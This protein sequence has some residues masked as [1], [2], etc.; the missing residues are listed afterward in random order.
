VF[1]DFKTTFSAG[2]KS[3][4]KEEGKAVPTS[5]DWTL[6]KTGT[7]S[8]KDGTETRVDE[9]IH[10]K[11]GDKVAITYSRNEG[12]TDAFAYKSA[13][14]YVVVPSYSNNDV[15]GFFDQNHS[16]VTARVDDLKLYSGVGHPDYADD[17][18]DTEGV[19]NAVRFA[20]LATTLDQSG[21]GNV[22]AKYGG[23][24][25]VIFTTNF[26]SSKVTA[27]S[28]TVDG[29]TV[30]YVSLASGENDST[31]SLGANHT[32]GKVF[33]A[34]LTFR[35]ITN[36]TKVFHLIRLRRQGEN[37]TSA[38]SQDIIKYSKNSNTIYFDYNGKVAY[39]CD[40]AGKKLT[41]S[42]NEW[43]T[44]R[45]VIDERGNKPLVSVYIN[46]KIANFFTDDALVPRKAINLEGIISDDFSAHRNDVDQKV[47][48]F[49]TIASS[50]NMDLLEAKVEYAEA[51]VAPVWADS[52]AL[53]FSKITDLSELGEQFLIS[54]GVYIENGELVVPAGETFGWLDYNGTFADF[55]AENNPDPTN[56]YRF[57]DGYA[58]EMKVKAAPTTALTGLVKITTD[59]LKNNNMMYIQNGKVYMSKAI[60]G[61]DVCDLDSDK[62]S[63]ISLLYT[64]NDARGTVF[65]DGKM[66]GVVG[67]AKGESVTNCTTKE[68][69]IT[70]ADNVRIAELYIHRDQ[71]RILAV[72]SGEIFELDPDAFLPKDPKSDDFYPITKGSSSG[73]LDSDT[74]AL[75]LYAATLNE[76]G[77]GNYYS[78]NMVETAEEITETN[79]GV[80]VK[81]QTWNDAV[82]TNYTEDNT[83]VFEYN[84]RFTPHKNARDNISIQLLG[85][86]RTEDG[87]SASKMETLFE[88]YETGRLTFMGY[89][90]CNADGSTYYLDGSKWVNVAVIYDSNSGKASIVVDGQILRYKNSAGTVIG[91]ANEVQLTN[92]RYYRMDA[93][94]TKIRFLNTA[95]DSSLSVQ[96]LGKLDIDYFKIYTLN[97]T[98]NVGYVGAQ[99]DTTDSNIRLVAGSDMLYY[100]SVGFDVEAFDA[101]GNSIANQTKTYTTN[102]VYSSIIENVKGSERAVYPED[103]GYRYFY[104]ANVMGVDQENAVKLNVTPFSIVNGV[105]YPASTVTL[106]IDF[107]GAVADWKLSDSDSITV[108]PTGDNVSANFST[109]D[110]V[111]YTN[112]GSLEFNGLDAKFAFAANL[113][114]GVVTVNLTNAKGEDC[115]SSIF[116]IYVDGVLTQEN[117]TLPFGHH[118]VVLAEGLKGEHEFMIVKKTG[119]DFVCINNMSVYGE[120]IEA[121]LLAQKDGVIVS[122]A[123]PA[124]GVP[125]GTVYVYAKT[126]DS[127]GKYYIKYQFSY[128]NDPISNYTYITGP[129][130]SHYNAKMYRINTAG[131]V[132]R[133]G[134]KDTWV[135]QLLQGGEISLAIKE[136]G[137][138]VTKAEFEAEKDLIKQLKEAS[139]DTNYIKRLDW[140]LAAADSDQETHS[141]AAG[142]FVGGWHGDENIEDGK[143]AMYLDG[144]KL[145]LTKAGTYTGTQFI[146]DQT[147]LIDRCDEPGNP[148]MRH[149]QYMLIDSNG[150]RNDQ[151]V[152]FLTND[153][154][155]DA[156]Q[157]YLQM[158]TFNRQNFQVAAADRGNP[159]TYICSNFNLLDAN[160]TLLS[161]HDLS[162]H[163]VSDGTKT[164]GRDHEKE[165]RYVE[166]LGNPNNAGKGLYGRVGFVIDDSSMVP[167][168]A[169]VMVRETQGDNKWYASFKSHNGTTIPVGEKWNISDYYYFDYAPTDYV[170]PDASK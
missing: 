20:E 47:L 135:Y 162:N 37:D 22:N 116:D 100:G 82:V 2:S 151:S 126:S 153:F 103:R 30:N 85:I 45:V 90:L 61:Y 120:I 106:D 38:V 75:K 136:S 160:G 112:K 164:L 54:D 9:Y 89:T 113:K 64:N 12:S 168:S 86:R 133:T 76:E 53:D 67:I 62:Y 148:V 145:D 46:G 55:R 15:L 108:K 96:A 163:K 7:P 143:I 91:L 167:N 161:N 127:S 139:S 154:V 63:D 131:I 4:S 19:I 166:Y 36:A 83:T 129:A 117:L 13:A 87:S 109:T 141:R 70:V 41:V 24:P 115:N 92:S 51:P 49:Q 146:C 57:N 144:V 69:A 147:C 71:Q 95:N 33:A 102:T 88:V 5:A 137:H 81:K 10:V 74:N 18:E 73:V 142:D 119:G 98:A 157:T 169:T 101:D 150:Y 125:Y 165:T 25:G 107:T 121:P 65:G 48:F 1:A 132:D 39:I 138:V 114:G 3:L 80:I 111:A 59:L 159:E 149:R 128:L 44:L 50:A 58:I 68:A 56:K 66:L 72:N 40:E 110:I 122:V 6:S 34:E 42:G 84:L 155:P 8:V 118:T 99:K 14:L 16:T 60:S 32:G 105:K 11:T 124:S 97:A 94:D 170:A 78:F 77:V 26:N 52:V 35:K 23:R 140:A 152:E 104:T 134:G 31:L 130:N 93:A 156:G 123:N 43:T 79:N 158:C 28:E 27:K 17:A 29:E 21:G